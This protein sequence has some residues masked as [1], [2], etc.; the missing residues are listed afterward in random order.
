MLSVSPRPPV[1]S[2]ACVASDSASASS[3]RS[4]KSPV[5]SCSLSTK[6]NG[7]ITTIA[8]SA[9]CRCE[10]RK[11]PEQSSPLNSRDNTTKCADVN[12]HSTPSHL[13]NVSTHSTP[14]HL[15]S[16]STRRGSSSSLSKR[17]GQHTKHVHFAEDAEVT[18][19][20]TICVWTFACRAA[21]KGPWEQ[22]ARDRAHF[23]RR[24]ETVAL[25]LEPCLTARRAAMAELVPNSVKS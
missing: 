9:C 21:R 2:T 18:S 25:V 22:F 10:H 23:R 7:L 12:T 16:V 20:H 11:T 24:I 5:Y 6:C 15:K 1:K 4:T 14:S 17:I 3:P 13:T 19:V 8:S